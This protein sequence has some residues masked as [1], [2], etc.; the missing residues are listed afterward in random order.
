MKEHL[1]EVE[2]VHR[3][4]LALFLKQRLY[5]R[6]IIIILLSILLLSGG[7]SSSEKSIEKLGLK[8]KFVLKGFNTGVEIYL[9]PD[10]T[11]INNCYSYGCTGGFRVKLVFGHYEIDSNQISFYPE[12]MV[13]KEDWQENHYWNYKLKF[14][15]ITYYE[16]DTTSI[17]KKYWL[18]Q[19]NHLKFLVS[20]SNFNEQDELFYKSSNFISLANLY[21]SNIEQ[22]T[23]E[24]LL[25]NKDTLWNFKNLNLKNIPDFYREL[26]LDTAINAKVISS[27]VYKINESFIPR[28]KLEVKE[29][30]KIKIGMKFYSQDFPDYPIQL[31]E[32]NNE[33]C[34]AE[35]YDLF[36]LNTKLK[37]NT[38]I[39]TE[40]K[41]NE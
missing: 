14:D 1:L 2:G 22:N 25:S 19:D 26:F 6:N 33:D 9:K 32:I 16:S 11:F 10:F 34:I 12:K 18:I 5:M 39:S 23:T 3:N 31:I 7:N 28:Y 17:H 36:Y 24:N 41:S 37:T 15:T 29:K 20:E 4:E 30:N 8:E 21:N 35:G 27:K 40:K 38:I 13:W